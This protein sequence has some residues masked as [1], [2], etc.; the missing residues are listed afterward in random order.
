[1]RALGEQRVVVA[2]GVAGEF[3]R[4]GHDAGLLHR[5]AALEEQIGAED[6]CARLNQLQ[7]RGFQ[8]AVGV[9]ER[10]LALVVEPDDDAAVPL[11]RTQPDDLHFLAVGLVEQRAGLFQAVAAI[12]LV[13]AVSI[14]RRPRWPACGR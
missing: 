10:G 12:L 7:H 2:E 3:A 1:M 13:S 9:A 5:F 6:G 11:L 14:P 8:A 4:I